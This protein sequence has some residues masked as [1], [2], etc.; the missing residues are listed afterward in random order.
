MAID[1]LLQ[2]YAVTTV[3]WDMDTKYKIRNYIY[4]L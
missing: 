3:K 1:K 4:F 2:K